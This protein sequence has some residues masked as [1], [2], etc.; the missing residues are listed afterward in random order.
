MRFGFPELFGPF[1]QRSV[2]RDL[3]VLDGLAAADDGGV[4]GDCPL[5]SLMTPSVSLISPSMASHFSPEA[6]LPS[7]EDRVQV[8]IWPWFRR[9]GQRRLQLAV[10]DGIDHLRQ[11]LRDGILSIVNVMQR[12]LEGVG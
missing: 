3:V 7:D 2:A 12:V 5:R 11:R 1:T 8:L 10:G 6:F 9:G 4:P